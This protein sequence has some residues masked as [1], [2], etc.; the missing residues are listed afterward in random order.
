[1]SLTVLWY[2]ALIGT[3]KTVVL[4]FQ[5]HP[6]QAKKENESSQQLQ[7]GDSLVL[8]SLEM[9]KTDK[10]VQYKAIAFNANIFHMAHTLNYTIHFFVFI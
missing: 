1:M 10:L 6:I 4:P 8:S 3:L 5:S 7:A 2:F 9:D